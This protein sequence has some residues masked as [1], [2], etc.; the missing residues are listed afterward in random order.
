MIFTPHS[1]LP[2]IHATFLAFLEQ[3]DKRWDRRHIA[4]L[5]DAADGRVIG[6]TKG[7]RLQDYATG[8]E[9]MP[10]YHQLADKSQS[11]GERATAVMRYYHKHKLAPKA[12]EL[13]IATKEDDQPTLF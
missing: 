1:A 7:Y 11:T 2:F 10:C 4:I 9:I 8:E 13:G 5:A 6:T 12:K 3:L